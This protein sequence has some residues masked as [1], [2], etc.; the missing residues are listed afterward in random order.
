MNIIETDFWGITNG[1]FITFVGLIAVAIVIYHWRRKELAL[2]SF[3]LFCLIYG[4]RWLAQTS[5]MQVLVG[6]PFSE[7]YVERLLSYLIAIP[8]SAFFILYFGQGIYRSMFWVFITIVAYALIAIVLDLFRAVPFNA[9]SYHPVAVILWC[10]VWAVNLVF[11]KRKPDIGLKVLRI[12]SIIF[13]LSI[14][15]D[16]MA[17]MGILPWKTHI[18]HT[19]FL[20]FCIGLSFIAG[21]HF[22]S[23]EKKLLSIEQE[24][25]I[26]RR[27]QYA[28]LPA[29]LQLP[30]GIDFAARY[31]PMST[32]AGDFYD[33]QIAEDGSVGILIADVSGHGVGAALIASMVKIAFASQVKHLSDPG[34]VLSEINTI[35][36]GNIEYSFIT[37]CYIHIDI[38]NG[39]IHYANAGHPIPLLWRK[40]G[41]LLF[42][43]S[44]HGIALGPVPNAVYDKECIDFTEG[45]RLIL[46]TDGITEVSNKAGEFFGLQ[47]LISFFESHSSSSAR[48]SVDQCVEHLAQWSGRSHGKSFDDDITLLV[49]DKIMKQSLH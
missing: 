28:I 22:F 45:D 42:S 41:E 40:S 8:I 2:L 39:K 9:P 21:H 10:L 35:L 48:S 23:S 37:A 5:T 12:V 32:I 44:V 1:M 4:I 36:E 46:F 18:E 26:A 25:E 6:F 7:P 49:V 30:P 16:Q 34:R 33:I 38:T 20:I 19:G 11:T 43:F 17:S 24:I 47:R 14:G 31:V 27:I 29:G 13:L 3:G 15:H